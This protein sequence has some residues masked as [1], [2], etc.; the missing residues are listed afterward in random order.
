MS[1]YEERDEIHVGDIGTSL[2]LIVKEA[3]AIV[4]IGAAT[5]L[6][7]RL[8]KPSGTTVGKTATLLTDG[9]DGIMR[10]VTVSGDLDEAGWWTRQGFFTLGS[11]TGAT[12]KVR[13]FV[14]P[15]L[16]TA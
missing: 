11:W 7:I 5:G 3:G 14:A 13:F 8:R 4:D 15:I 16:E 12:D 2:G 6:T 9:S 10:Y 1:E